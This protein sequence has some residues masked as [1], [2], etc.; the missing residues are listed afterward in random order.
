MIET[1]TQEVKYYPSHWGGVSDLGTLLQSASS[2]HQLT[3]QPT[4]STSTAKDFITQLTAK[5]PDQRLSCKEALQH[6]WL[7]TETG[8]KQDIERPVAQKL[9]RA[10]TAK[11][12][13]YYDGCEL[14]KQLTQLTQSGETVRAS[15]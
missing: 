4:C 2:L 11:A 7:H 10:P 8:H 1:M 14:A 9:I 3:D 13:T 12:E 5:D 15:A 6:P